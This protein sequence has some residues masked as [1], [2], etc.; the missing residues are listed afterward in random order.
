M[1][2]KNFQ[3]QLLSSNKIRPNRYEFPAGL[4]TRFGT[5]VTIDYMIVAGGGGGGATIGGGGG[6]GGVVLG[7]GY[8]AQLTGGESGLGDFRITIG[9]GG[10]GGLT[11]SLRGANGSNTIF[12]T[13]TEA[14]GGGGGGSPSAGNKEGIAGGSGG[15]GGGGTGAPA[16]PAWASGGYGGSGFA[17]QGYDGGGGNNY[18]PPPN[19]GGFGGGGGGGAGGVGAIGASRGTGEGGA[20]IQ[21]SLYTSPIW[22][23]NGGSG[24]FTSNPTAKPAAAPSNTGQGGRGT[25]SGN[26]GPA[27]GGNAGSGAVI[28]KYPLATQ[29]ASGGTV[30]QEGGAT[31]HLFTG[32]GFFNVDPLVAAV[33]SIN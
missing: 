23:A 20:G 30:I 25:N 26:P 6:G 29:A 27:E 22:Y 8:D 13:F 11:P 3:Q 31:I 12:H 4:N 14:Y 16:D 15:G 32:D 17:P 2:I 18:A 10:V 1:S 9:A 28:I 5:L 19:F 33:Y 24:G 7:S 21:T